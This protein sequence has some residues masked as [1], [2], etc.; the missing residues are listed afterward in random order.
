MRITS[1]RSKK[2]LLIFLQILVFQML[3]LSAL[4]QETVALRPYSRTV[5]LTGFTYPLQEMT[6]TSEVSGRCLKI[7][8]DIGDTVPENGRLA[9]IDTTFIQLDIEA[10]RIAR[11]Q[12][13]RQLTKEEK[14]LARYTTLLSQKSTPQAQLDEVALAADLYRINLKKL[15]NEAARLQEQLARHSLTGPPGWQLIERYAEAGEFIQAGKAVARLGDF[16][17]LLIPLAVTYGELQA[18]S[19][20]DSLK[21]YLP[22][23]DVTVAGAIYRTSPLFDPKTRKIQIDLIIEAYHE[24]L[25][26]PLRGGMRAELQFATEEKT[27]AFLVPSSALISRYEAH[28]LMRPDGTRMQVIFQGQ[29]NDGQHAI[30]SGSEL[31]A[32]QRFLAD[33]DTFGQ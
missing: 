16:R 33:P 30:I 20:L 31:S 14:S 29:S 11:E 32:G 8:A 7:F 25:Q 19:Q 17:R 13:S 27:A 18:I 24:R 9:E 5:T 6:I 1:A 10:N 26:V 3:P 12:T 4:C 22:D 21:L 15:H 2:H 28:W 23:I